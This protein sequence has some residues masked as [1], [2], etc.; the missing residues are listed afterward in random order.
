MK[1]KKMNKTEI[2]LAGITGMWKGKHLSQVNPLK[3]QSKAEIQDFLLVLNLYNAEVLEDMDNTIV[4]RRMLADIGIY[5]SE[6]GLTSDEEHL[7]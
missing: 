6:E 1:H 4:A 2:E 7:L 3:I 5:C